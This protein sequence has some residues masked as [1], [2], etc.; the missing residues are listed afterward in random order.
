MEQTIMLVDAINHDKN[1]SFRPSSCIL[2]NFN[3]EDE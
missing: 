1:E 3:L 2:S